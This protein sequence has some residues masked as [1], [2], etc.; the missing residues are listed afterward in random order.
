MQNATGYHPGP[1]LPSRAD[2]GP[3]VDASHSSIIESKSPTHQNQHLSVRPMRDAARRRRR[4]RARAPGR[5]RRVRPN[6]GPIRRNR[7]SV[8]LERGVMLRIG[9]GRE[10]V[11]RFFDDR[12]GRHRHGLAGLDVV[13]DQLLHR[14][15]AVVL[16]LVPQKC[17]F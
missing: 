2:V 4:A 5:H 12:A 3:S 10:P 16:K 17:S 6:V 11:L 9:S 7:K 15:E 8:F 14:R 13:K 1:A